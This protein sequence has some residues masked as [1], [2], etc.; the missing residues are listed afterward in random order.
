M[1][2]GIEAFLLVGEVLLVI[3]E[4]CFEEGEEAELMV[5]GH[6]VGEVFVVILLEEALIA[7]IEFAFPSF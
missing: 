7:G 5:L 6:W 4:V 3:I 1:K 2:P